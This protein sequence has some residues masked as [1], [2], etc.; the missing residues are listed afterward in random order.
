[1]KYKHWMLLL[2][3][4]DFLVFFWCMYRIESETAS[5]PVVYAVLAVVNLFA[6]FY[7]GGRLLRDWDTLR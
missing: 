4:S 6:G 2:V 7:F 3:I 1:M 5:D